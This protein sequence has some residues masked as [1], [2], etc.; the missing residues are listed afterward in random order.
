MS[1]IS[2]GVLRHLRGLDI[3]ILSGGEIDRRCLGGQA[4]AP[5]TS[6]LTELVLSPRYWRGGLHNPARLRV[7]RFLW[8]LDLC[9]Q[10]IAKVLRQRG[11]ATFIVARRSIGGWPLKLDQF[12][13]EAFERQQIHLERSF[14]RRIEGKMTPLVINKQGRSM[15]K[16]ESNGHVRT[17]RE[18]HMLTFYKD[19]V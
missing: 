12:L 11:R 7:Y 8:D 1:S 15:Q 4:V 9:V 19:K 18:E 17:I 3:E 16:E 10:E 5:T 13:V 6:K 2:L 14:K